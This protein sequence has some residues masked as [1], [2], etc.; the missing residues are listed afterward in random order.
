MFVKKNN[1][2]GAA[3]L[4]T[5]AVMA[6]ITLVVVMSVDRSS[7]DVELSYNQLHE[8]QAFYVADAGL[9]TAIEEI[10]DDEDW[11]TGFSD[12]PFGQGFFT[13]TITDSATDSAL[14]DTIILLSVGTVDEANSQLELTALPIPKTPF[15]YAMYGKD[16]IVLDKNACTDS[17][18]SDSGSYAAT[19]LDSMGNIG[20]N[21]TVTTSKDVTVG[22]GIQTATPG[23]IT[24]G[25]FNT[26]NGDTTTT[27]DSAVFDLVDS[28]D[29]VWAK[30]NSNAP[31]GLT[32]A[33]YVYNSVDQNLTMGAWGNVNLD[34]GVY[35]FSDMDFGQGATLTLTPGA[36]VEIYVTGTIHFAQSSTANSGG[37]PSDMIIYSSGPLLQFDQAN[38]FYGIFYGPNAHTQY[39]Q[40]TNFYGSLISGT[41]KLDQ[42]ACFHFDRDLMNYKAGYTHQVER[43]AWREVY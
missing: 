8:E 24:L 22:G 28:S 30:A 23:G 26:V 27:A 36:S 2:R 35:Y 38:T 25:P 1:E 43:I 21:G 18:N 33:G 12:E 3:L 31:A 29:F 11:R 16:G 4:I 5:L 10:E 39:D 9:K 17:Y 37:T 34:A 13:V 32:G 42:G 19:M 7:T 14:I 15:M 6:M 20:S 40:T 41:I